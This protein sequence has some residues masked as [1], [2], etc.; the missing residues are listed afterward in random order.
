M[1][2]ENQII[3]KKRQPLN[4]QNGK[5]YM[6]V[7]PINDKIYVGSTATELCVR[8]WRHKSD[9]YKNTHNKIFYDDLKLNRTKFK[10]ILIENFPC[11]SKK[12]LE[13]R[14][15]EVIQQK[16]HELGRDKLYNL[17]LSKNGEGHSSYGKKISEQT[18]QK[19][20]QANK[21]KQ[22]SV[23]NPFYGKK[24]SEETKRK[25]SVLRQGKY[26]GDKSPNF[27][28]GNIHK[29]KNNIYTF[30]WTEHNEEDKTRKHRSKSFSINKYGE[31]E[32]YK[33]C[34][35]FQKLIYPEMK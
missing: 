4:Y 7:N 32:A 29:R 20:S 2:N 26:I 35:E 17:C 11:N 27:K 13:K 16:V 3:Q 18:K 30:Q 28:N 22:L 25:I 19:I 34:L 12:E 9:A 14:E 1:T 31:E 33:L 10:I 6:I 8:L 21:G 15:Y 5:I 23:N 24:H